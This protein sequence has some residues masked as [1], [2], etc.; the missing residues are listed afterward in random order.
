MPPTKEKI[1]IIT[2]NPQLDYLLERVLKS[3]GYMVT[4]C[5][6]KETVFGT[7]EKVPHE[8]VIVSEEISGSTW[9]RFGET[10]NTKFPATPVILLVRSRTPEILQQALMVGISGTLCLPLNPKRFWMQWNPGLSVH[11]SADPGS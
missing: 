10:L 7:L 11:A 3:G 4:L 2:S 1:L 8:L 9:I 5:P 6:E